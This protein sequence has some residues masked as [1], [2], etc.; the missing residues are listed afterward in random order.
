M[1]IRLTEGMSLDTGALSRDLIKMQYERNDVTP[2]RG[3]FRIRGEVIEIYPAYTKGAVRIELDWDE[4]KSIVKY[5][6]VSGEVTGRFE[7][8]T[9]Y[10]A[11][12]LL[13]LRIS[14]RKLFQE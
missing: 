3:S 9:I 1:R 14:L 13:F 7:F 8:L 2:G 5:D 6:P 12:I 11:N 4:V 10:P